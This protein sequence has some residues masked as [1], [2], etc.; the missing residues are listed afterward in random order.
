VLQKIRVQYLPQI[1]ETVDSLFGLILLYEH[2]QR[3]SLNPS[4]QVQHETELS[5][6]VR[7][8]ANYLYSK[9][10]PVADVLAM[11]EHH[12]TVTEEPLLSDILLF[13]STKIQ[14]D[15]CTKTPF[16]STETENANDTSC[17]M[18]TTLLATVLE[19][20]ALDKLTKIRHIV[21]HELHSDQFP[22]LNEFNA[23]YAY[24]CG[25]FEECLEMS[26]NHVNMLLRAG[27]RRNQRYQ[28]IIP[29]FHSMLDGELV[30]LFGFIKL[31][32]PVLLLFL[33]QFPFCESISMLTLCLYL[34]VQCQKN[35]RSDSLCDTL[36]LIRVV[37][38]KVFPADDNE[39]YL[40][41]LIL[42]LTYRSLKLY[43]DDSACA[44]ELFVYCC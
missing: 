15:E 18:D 3:V 26:Q 34:M 30:S 25:L 24:K 11:H 42:K 9:C 29:E 16:V 36:Q 28:A 12:L 5:F 40:D 20:E 32:H 37:H 6:T 17:S 10:S 41:R 22:L 19:L 2:V 23:L 44:D 7:L 14:L 21:I 1:D 13:K 31:M 4:A 39:Y 43:V 8:L 35:L 38:D 27:A 33:V